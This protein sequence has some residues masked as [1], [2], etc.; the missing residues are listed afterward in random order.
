MTDKP[1]K[2]ILLVDFDGV[3]HSYAS[4]WR[5]ADVIPDDPVDGAFQFLYCATS[6]F[7]VNVYS[8]RSSEPNGIEAMRQWFDYHAPKNPDAHLMTAHWWRTDLHFPREKPAAFLTIDDR[9]WCFEGAF[10]LPE[11]LLLFE[12]WNKRNRGD[13]QRCMVAPM[14]GDMVFIA[15]ETASVVVPRALI[16]RFVAD[17]ETSES[18]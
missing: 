5:G 13:F 3:I 7:H 2:P 11:D 12:P 17:P 14:A 16:D 4:G 9:C 6:L 18:R 15:D 1:R 10:P 8:S